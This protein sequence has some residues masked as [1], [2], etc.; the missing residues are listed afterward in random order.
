MDAASDCG[1][2][3]LSLLALLVQKD[4]ST[5]GY[6]FSGGRSGDWGSVVLSLLAFTSTKGRILTRSSRLTWCE[7]RA[8]SKRHASK[9]LKIASRCNDTHYAK[10]L[11]LL[12]LLVQKYRC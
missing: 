10:V 11:D 6:R 9:M 1:S 5:K 2:V 3:V 8:T 4:T 7:L 12:P